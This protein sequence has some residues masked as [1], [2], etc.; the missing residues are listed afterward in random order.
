MNQGLDE[1]GTVTINASQG[2]FNAAGSILIGPNSIP[3]VLDPIVNDGC[4]QILDDSA[5]GSHGDL[6]GDLNIIGCHATA[7]D[8]GISVEGTQ[9]GDVT[10]TQTG[11]TNPGRRVRLPVIRIV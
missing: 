7:D 6:I 2:D 4:I 9:T 8:L 10:I 5:D 1:N 3:L 11:C